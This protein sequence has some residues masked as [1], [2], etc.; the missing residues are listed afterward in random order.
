MGWYPERTEV[1][2]DEKNG[3]IINALIFRKLTQSVLLVKTAI[4]DVGL[5]FLHISLEEHPRMC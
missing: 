3:L 4:T 1:E 2:T 5:V